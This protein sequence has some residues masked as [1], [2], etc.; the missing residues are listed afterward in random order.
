MASTSSILDPTRKQRATKPRRPRIDTELFRKISENNVAT[1]IDRSTELT[2]SSK[3][4]LKESRRLPGNKRTYRIA[5]RPRALEIA[6][7]S[8]SEKIAVSLLSKSRILLPVNVSS[9]KKY[10][11]SSGLAIV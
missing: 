11:I 7:I 6:A 9:I 8:N 10:F 5:A 1:G 3:D 4:S 2:E